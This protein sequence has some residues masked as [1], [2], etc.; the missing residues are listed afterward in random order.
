M[1]AKVPA[2]LLKYLLSPRK[3]QHDASIT[4]QVAVSELRRVI[5]PGLKEGR[6]SRCVKS[7][8]EGYWI[9]LAL[10][11]TDVAEFLDRSRQG[12]QAEFN[13][14]SRRALEL[15]RPAIALYRGDLLEGFDATDLEGQRERLRQQFFKVCLAAAGISLELGGLDDAMDLARR[16]LAADRCLEQAHRL[17]MQCYQR[18]GRADL[19]QQQFQQC[20]SH[21]RADLGL[22]ASEETVALQARLA[23]GRL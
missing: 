12:Q 10:A 22:D 9:D 16:A 17:L 5:E 7:D 18:Q 14:Q 21:L 3:S 1:P 15:Y 4:L 13:N 8:G 20:R 6:E 2:D 23:T 11:A 19:A